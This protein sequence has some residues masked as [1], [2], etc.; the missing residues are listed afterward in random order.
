MAAAYLPAEH[1][2]AVGGD[3]YKCRRLRDGRA[4]LAIGDAVGHGLD[5]V[6]RMAQQ[7][8]ALAGL[9]QTGA[10]AGEMTTWL[11]ELLCSDASA[12]TATMITGHVDH[13][14]VLRWA[15]AGHPPPL[16]RRGNEVSPLPSDHLGPLLGLTPGYAYETAEVPLRSG[17]LLLLYTDGVVE[18]RGEDIAEGIGNLSRSLSDNPGLS[19]GE[20]LDRIIAEYRRSAHDDDACLLA[21]QAD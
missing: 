10:S 20:T 4:L 21:V 13:D 3:W 19:P 17:D 7:R 5:A 9:A 8:H 11:N 2:A 12:M 16:L 1:D 15:C 18:R 6:A 14:R